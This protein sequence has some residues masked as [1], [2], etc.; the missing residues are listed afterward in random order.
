VEITNENASIFERSVPVDF[1]HENIRL[2]IPTVVTMIQKKEETKIVRSVD[3]IL[4]ELDDNL[5]I[6]FDK[7]GAKFES[8]DTNWFKHS[9]LVLPDL[10]EIF[11]LSDE[12]IQKYYV[13]HYLDNLEYSEKLEFI[14][15]LYSE[16]KSENTLLEKI[17]KY[18][19]DEKIL[20]YAGKK[21]LVLANKNE[22][23]I[24]IQSDELVTLWN[25]ARPTERHEINS[26]I[27]EKYIVAKSDFNDIIGFMELF[28]DRE[29]T[30]KVKD[31]KQKRNNKGS[32]CDNLGN[33]QIIKYLNE[34]IGGEPIY[35]NEN[36]KDKY[37]KIS[38]CVLTEI[39]LRYYDETRRND[40]RW[41]F[42][43]EQ[44]MIRDVSKL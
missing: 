30:F 29:M 37:T 24:L 22:Y 10:I 25:E 8:R 1:K 38:L 26:I 4:R 34:I 40:K 44:A 33:S 35:D 43:I 28:K 19:F 17:I 31:M 6:A 20:D 12:F 16:N 2:E 39:L 21:A 41:F 7:S 27:N 42:N 14:Q 11:E 13:Y 23:K 15:T 9:T 3:D 32:R 18:Y 36:I 5:K